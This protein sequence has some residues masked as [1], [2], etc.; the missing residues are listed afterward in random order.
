MADESFAQVAR[1][2]TKGV[3]GD[4]ELRLEAQAEVLARLEAATDQYTAE[5]MS[6][7]DRNARAI[8]S[9]GDVKIL[10]SELTD[11][12]RPRIRRRRWAHCLLLICIPF[13]LICSLLLFYDGIATTHVLSFNSVILASPIDLWHI[14]LEALCPS[15]QTKRTPL[16]LRALW[17]ANPDNIILLG[18][19]ASRLHDCSQIKV[20]PDALQALQK[21]RQLDPGNAQPCYLQANWELSE[22][23]EE[24]ED[25]SNSP[26]NWSGSTSPRKTVPAKP[27][28]FPLDPF[29]NS[30][31]AKLTVKDRAKLDHAMI[32]LREGMKK[33]D[34]RDYDNENYHPDLGDLP[35]PNRFDTYAARRSYWPSDS[36]SVAMHESLLKRSAFYAHLLVHE[37]R[38]TDVLPYLNYWRV[39]CRKV[40]HGATGL[41]RLNSL[42]HFSYT[43]A[44]SAAIVYREMKREDLAK[45]AL[46]DAKQYTDAYDASCQWGMVEFPHD[47]LYLD[48]GKL[49]QDSLAP[50]AYTPPVTFTHEEL[51]PTRNLGYILHEECSLAI[52]LLIIAVLML[53][54]FI[55]Q[56]IWTFG[57]SAKNAPPLRLLIP[58]KVWGA[59]C[60]F[61]VLLPIGAY[62]VFTR[63]SSLSGRDISVDAL[64][65]Y[66]VIE[67]SVV[68]LAILLIP[69]W[70]AV[71]WLRRRCWDLR[72]PYLLL[73][74]RVVCKKGSIP[75]RPSFAHFAQYRGTLVRSLLPVMAVSTLL[76]IA[77]AVPYLVSQEIYWLQRD[78]VLVP[79]GLSTTS[80]AHQRA[81][82]VFKARMEAVADRLAPSTIQSPR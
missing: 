58:L 2:A 76:T 35:T 23:L 81:F 44:E 27:Q 42:K 20:F 43:G 18:H 19:Y 10:A 38:S 45:Q 63:C 41:G 55:G 39:L 1:E 25:Y 82:A 31:S 72:F 3:Q 46:A 65:S 67:V 53:T 51:T 24:I 29:A 79:K 50:F 56:C 12:Y 77:I 49:I 66:F 36:S 54:F 6:P 9:L 64:G 60:G 34:L 30:S 8:A 26:A 74:Y 14:S 32:I 57:S 16:S 5:D 61:G 7:E 78:T 70:I 17:Q 37:G 68:L 21:Y 11:R 33:T 69:R 73:T 62:Y 52:S 13:A 4:L 71:R 22:A 40:A 80:P 28:P 48:G 47:S 75:S 59:L 15:Y